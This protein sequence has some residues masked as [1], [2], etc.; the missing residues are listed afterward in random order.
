M[1]AH[2][3]FHAV[4]AHLHEMRGDIAAARDEYATAARQATNL[5]QHRY[6]HRQ[7]ARLDAL[8]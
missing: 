6:L 1:N 8:A 5:Q 4:R 3:R 2:R 7:I